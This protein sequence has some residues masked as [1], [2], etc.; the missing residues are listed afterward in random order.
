MNKKGVL[1][2]CATPIGNLKDI[3]IRVMEIL[4]DVDYIA[5]EDTRRTIK[6]LNY[7][8]INT[9]LLSYHEHNKEKRGLELIELL[10]K[11]KKIALVSDAGTPGLSDP[12][13]ELIKESI[14][15]DIEVT[16]LPGPCAAVAAVTV[17]GFPIK[18]FAFYGFL[19]SKKKERRK[20][21]KEIGFENKTVVI[22][23]APHRLLKTLEELTGYLAGREIAVCREL[24]KKFEEIKRGKLPELIGYFKESS[25]KGEIS[26][27]IEPGEWEELQVERSFT[28]AAFEV[29]QLKEAGVKEKEAVKIIARYFNLSSKD[30]YKKIIDEKENFNK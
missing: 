6:L 30:L 11:E 21:L 16:S 29:R 12:G 26:I 8:N 4:K 23:E 14:K 3:T 7:Y 13:F 9:P 25:P 22:Y 10:E 5:A 1:Y 24:T 27:V 2:L 20:E 19:S 17:S 15:K 28:E 18:R